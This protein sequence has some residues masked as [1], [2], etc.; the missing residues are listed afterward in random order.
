VSEALALVI[1]A[2]GPLA[3]AT[4]ATY[5]RGAHIIDPRIGEPTTELASAT[6]VGPDLT[7]ADVYAT[8][9][10]V[11]GLDGLKWIE[12]RNGYS[13]YVVTYDDET[14]WTPQF[15]EFRLNAAVGA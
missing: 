4:S 10:F 6:V 7:V 3:I 2:S 8:T 5:E 11:M 9:L 1:E 15:N 12:E 13:A 14:F